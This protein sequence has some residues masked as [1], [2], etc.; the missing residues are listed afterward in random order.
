MTT[1]VKPVIVERDPGP[2]R[3][4]E[5]LHT[6]DLEC[7]LCHR[8]DC[9]ALFN[10]VAGSLSAE[11]TKRLD[12]LVRSSVQAKGRSCSTVAYW[13][14]GGG[15]CK[16]CLESVTKTIRPGAESPLRHQDSRFHLFS[17]TYRQHI[18]WMSTFCPHPD[19]VTQGETYS[20]RF[21][22]RFCGSNISFIMTC[23]SLSSDTRCSSSVEG[24]AK[25]LESVKIN[26]YMNSQPQTGRVRNYT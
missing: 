17:M 8:G 19:R 22:R 20:R 15:Y 10:P 7:R 26:R 5:H 16:H 25:E 14:G 13:P 1:P 9:D 23:F 24:F 21:S 6:A 4:A 18:P 2:D 12:D 11:E 3:R